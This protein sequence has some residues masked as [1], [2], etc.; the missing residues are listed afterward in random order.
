MPVDDTE[1]ILLRTKNYFC[2]EFWMLLYLV[3]HL[4][5]NIINMTQ[6]LSKVMDG[7]TYATFLEMH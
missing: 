1:K 3:K 7:T 6:E 4:K 2:L 5:P